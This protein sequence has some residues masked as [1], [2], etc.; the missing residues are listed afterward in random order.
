MTRMDTERTRPKSS[1]PTARPPRRRKARPTTS[2]WCSATSRAIARTQIQEQLDAAGS[3]L[4]ELKASLA[5][6]S[7]RSSWQT[8]GVH[9]E[10]FESGQSM[11]K[12]VVKDPEEQM[13]F[14][15]EPRPSNFFD[16]A[17]PWRPGEPPRPMSSRRGT[18]RARRS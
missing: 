16:E 11:I 14:T 7:G 2:A 4:E 1:T 13:A 9:V 8:R 15:V 18:S 10:V 3:R 12:G 6:R 17:R 5:E